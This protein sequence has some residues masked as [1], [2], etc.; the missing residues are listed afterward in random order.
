M[1]RYL[2]INKRINGTYFKYLQNV[3][4]DE[5]FRISDDNHF[6]FIVG[7]YYLE[8]VL[9]FNE[10]KTVSLKRKYYTKL[11][12]NKKIITIIR[13]NIDDNSEIKGIKEKYSFKNDLGLDSMDMINLSIDIEREFF[14][15]LKDD[16]LNKIKTVK[17]LKEQ[18]KFLIK[19]FENC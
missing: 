5:E 13:N 3:D 11:D 2:C 6:A 16:E 4:I 17:D 18:L 10:D 14:V 7:E 9:T 12:F 1:K 19:D 8:D 15:C